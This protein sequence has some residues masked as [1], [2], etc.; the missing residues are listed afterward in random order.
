MTEQHYSTWSKVKCELINH[1]L[2]H[3][4]TPSPSVLFLWYVFCR[5]YVCNVVGL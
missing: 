2:P 3:D 1:F 5:P 4:A